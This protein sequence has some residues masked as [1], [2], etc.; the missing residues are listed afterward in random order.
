MKKIIFLLLLTLV[1][2]R[3]TAQEKYTVNGATHELKSEVTG[4]IDLLWNIIDKE[5]RYFVRKDGIITE[6]FNTKGNE[7]KFKEEYKQTLIAL[8]KGSYQDTN[9]V[10][11]T[12]YSLS[13]FV[14][15]Y[16]NTVDPNYISTAIVT[17]LKSRLLVFGG[18]TNNPFIINPDNIKTPLF[19]AEIEVYEGDFSP[20]HALF[21]EVK[22][23]LEHADFKYSTTQLSL[24][25]RFR[26]IN[27]ENF[28]LYANVV[29]GTYNFSKN[30]FTYV[31]Q[32][33]ELITQ[34]NTING[35][36]A[37]LSFGIGADFKVSPNGFITFTY[38]ELFA[39]L[40]ENKGN[41]ST[42]FALGYKFN[43]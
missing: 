31:D 22:H 15:N 3:N 7:K 9:N 12:L 27:S 14:N 38:N 8:T 39:L 43:L 16:N 19:G 11:F 21:F 29:F 40:S 4:A 32:N 10:K 18:I 42:N 5:Y 26:F 20:R 41:F 13:E 25:Y 30:T 23:V 34:E 1:C 2:F 35:F 6:L 28:N 36:D 37:P 24:G 17:K 33:D